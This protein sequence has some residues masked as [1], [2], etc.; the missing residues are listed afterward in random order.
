ML[1][2][3]FHLNNKIKWTIVEPN[4]RI[5]K[6]IKVKVIKKFF[7][8]KIEIPSSID[9]FTHSHVIEHIYDLHKFM[10]DLDDKILPGKLMIFSIPEK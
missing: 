8:E 7:D 1:Y 5:D 4:P 9:V 3:Y 2:Q 10:K 6:K